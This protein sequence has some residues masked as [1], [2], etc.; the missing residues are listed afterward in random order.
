[1][2]RELVPAADTHAKAGAKGGRG[3]KA[4]EGTIKAG[5]NTTSFQERGTTYQLRRLKRD[6]P[7]LAKKV[8]AGEITG[9]AAAIQAGFRQRLIQHPATVDGFIQAATKHLS[10]DERRQLCAKLIS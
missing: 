9:N 10:T 8:V 3:K 6:R 1:L 2:I 5:S 4:N 7:D